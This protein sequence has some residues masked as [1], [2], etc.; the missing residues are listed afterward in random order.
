MPLQ[1]AVGLR[2]ARTEHWH[3]DDADCVIAVL[4]AQA[5]PFK[6]Q[7]HLS[8]WSN[9][10]YISGVGCSKAATTVAPVPV[11]HDRKLVNKSRAVDESSPDLQPATK[12]EPRARDGIPTQSEAGRVKP[13]A[14]FAKQMHAA[15]DRRH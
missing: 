3:L 2:V 6:L 10:E 8:T 9:S 13:E 14:R 1:H 5:L 4:G 7:R 11:A 15:A 12:W